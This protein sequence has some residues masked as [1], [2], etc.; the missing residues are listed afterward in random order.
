MTSILQIYFSFEIAPE[1]YR[2]L[3]IIQFKIKVLDSLPESETALSLTKR[4]I[5][6]GLA[7]II[8]HTLSLLP[9]ILPSMIKV[10]IANTL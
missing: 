4:K 7:S 1:K 3:T 5:T 2:N 10:N 6:P 9:N 8:M